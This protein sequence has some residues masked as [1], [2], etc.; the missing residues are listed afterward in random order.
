MLTLPVLTMGIGFAL[1]EITVLYAAF[2]V[3]VRIVARLDLWR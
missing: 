3:F 1:L 2:C